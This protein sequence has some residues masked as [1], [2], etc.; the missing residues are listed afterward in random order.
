VKHAPRQE[1]ARTRRGTRDGAG[2]R[3]VSVREIALDV[4]GEWSHQRQYAQ[5]LLDTACRRHSLSGPDAA[6]LHLIVLGVVRHLSLL[7]HWTDELCSHRHLDHRSRWVL[8][9]GLVQVL[10][11]DLPPHAAVNESVNIA[12]RARGLVNAVL[13]RAVREREQ[14]LAAADAW[15]LEIRT[16]HPAFL[17]ARW[18]EAF[19]GP[20]TRALCEWNQQPAANYVRLNPLHPDAAGCVGRMAESEDLG[21]GFH[22]CATLPRDALAAG[23]CY[24]QDP[25]T[26]IAPLM[27]GARP[28]ELVLDACAAPG[29]KTAILAAAMQNTGRIIAADSSSARLPRLRDNLRRLRVANAVVFEHDLTS[30]RAAPWGDQKFD[31]ILLDAP[32]SNTGVMRRRVDVRWRLHEDDFEILAAVQRRLLQ[33]AVPLLKPGGSLVYST[34]SVDAA[35]NRAVVEAALAEH[36]FLALDAERFA[37]P[38]EAGSDGAYA[39]LLTSRK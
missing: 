10:V 34:C 13:R 21:G 14:W 30:R 28:G 7:D 1:P 27:L 15:P 23:Q 35:E 26:A 22:R 32:C 6:L 9:I 16:S 5:D 17:V 20:R 3:G 8:R 38:P 39:A 29:G 31:R 25:S 4:L 18:Q 36:P 11:L 2:A 37:F 19:G 33:A 24:A 12:G